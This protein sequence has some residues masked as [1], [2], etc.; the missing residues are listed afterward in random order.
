MDLVEVM[1]PVQT[2]HQRQ[3]LKNLNKIPNL[4]I[5]VRKSQD[6]RITGVS[7]V[8]EGGQFYLSLSYYMKPITGE[9]WWQFDDGNALPAKCKARHFTLRNKIHKALNWKERKDKEK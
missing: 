4:D 7:I 3:S 2:A 1:A 6:K 8:A 9:E 5:K